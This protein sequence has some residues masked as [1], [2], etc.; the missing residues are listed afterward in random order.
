MDHQELDYE[1]A[2]SVPAGN[3]ARVVVEGVQKLVYILSIWSLT[4]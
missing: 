1:F 2:F 3:L 4:S